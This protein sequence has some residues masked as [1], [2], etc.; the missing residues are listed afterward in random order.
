V[1]F[2]PQE[3]GSIYFGYGTSFNPSAEGLSLAASTADL[4]PE[5]SKSYEV[6]TKWDLYTNR[7]AVNAAYFRTLKINARTPGVNPGD[8]PTVLN[9]RQHVDGVELG[10]IGNITRQ[11][12]AIGGYTFM[13]S[14]IDQSNNAAE[15][16]REFA[17]T[18]RHSFNIW[19]DYQFPWKV[20]IGGGI[21]YVGDRFVSNTLSRVAAGYWVADVTAAYHVTERLSL[22]LNLT[23]LTNKRYIDRLYTGHF[24]PGPGRLAMIT[25]DFRF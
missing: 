14:R 18:P 5:K 8:P 13:R 22:R 25:T 23:N 17:N 7:V 4:Q 21:N 15:A 11:W 12:Q 24:I 9:G 1:V 19:T 20:D 10:L 6:G 2:K 16:G 3:S